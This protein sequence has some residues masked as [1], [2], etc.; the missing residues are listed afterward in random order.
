MRILRRDADR[1]ALGW[2]ENGENFWREP[3]G[4][5][6]V[7]ERVGTVEEFTRAA[8]EKLA[9]EEAPG[10]IYVDTLGRVTEVRAARPSRAPSALEMLAGAGAGKQPLMALTWG[11]VRKAAEAYK[12]LRE[13]AT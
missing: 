7:V 10:E 3:A 11:D 1:L 12:K 5:E 4:G 13:E 8:K 2:R 9:P 6:T